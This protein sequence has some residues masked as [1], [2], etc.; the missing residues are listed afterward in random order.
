MLGHILQL[1]YGG[2]SQ[3]DQYATV[4]RTTSIQRITNIKF[5]NYY[6]QIFRIRNNKQ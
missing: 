2:P 4:A 6:T 3:F 5:R 1:V